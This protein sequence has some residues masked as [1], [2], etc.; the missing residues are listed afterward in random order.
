MVKQLKL[1]SYN[2][3]K[4]NFPIVETVIYSFKHVFIILNKMERSY[5]IIFLY[6]IVHFFKEQI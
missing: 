1:I 6:F 5:Y 4:S 3:K 2:Q